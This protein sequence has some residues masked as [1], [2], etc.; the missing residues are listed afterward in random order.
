[1]FGIETWGGSPKSLLAKIQK[2][3]NRATKLAVADNKVFKSD[4]QRHREL[5][6]LDINE[7]IKYA[8]LV[9]TYKI[10]HWGVPEVLSSLMPKNTRN[11]QRSRDG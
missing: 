9:H 4:R 6:W 3:Q 10:L 1:M 7:D 2:L 11:S 8:T 5:N